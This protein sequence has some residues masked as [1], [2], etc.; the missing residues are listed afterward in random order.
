MQRGLLVATLG[1]FRTKDSVATVKQFEQ[2]I[3]E[4]PDRPKVHDF[5]G[6]RL[7]EDAAPQID[8]LDSAIASLP[9]THNFI[10]ALAALVADA[11]RPIENLQAFLNRFI[12]LGV[13]CSSPSGRATIGEGRF[14]G[15]AVPT[16]MPTNWSPEVWQERQYYASGIRQERT[17]SGTAIMLLGAAFR[18]N[19]LRYPDA[20]A[21]YL[22]GYG[23]NQKLRTAHPAAVAPTKAS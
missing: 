16:E 10:E 15:Y 7:R 5:R 9:L 11:S 6:F 23:T 17:V 12:H 13:R 1:S 21:A 22:A 4:P 3:F 20:Q 8:P 2:A 14:L 19:G 18:E